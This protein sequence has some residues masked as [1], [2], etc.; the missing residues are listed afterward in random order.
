MFSTPALPGDLRRPPRPARGRSKLESGI[1]RIL[2]LSSLIACAPLGLP[3]AAR[4]QSADSSDA[5]GE[6][7][8]SGKA[9]AIASRA[10]EA[11]RNAYSDTSLHNFRARAE[12]HVFFLGE[13][14][15]E[16]EVVR[17]D[18]VALE[19]MWQAPGR[20]LQR[21]VGRRH[22]KRLPTGIRYHID[23]LSVVLDNFGNRIRLGEGQEVRD[24]LHPAAPG[25]LRYYQYRLVDSLEIRIRDQATRVYRLQVR[26]RDPKSPGVVGTLFVD[27]ASAAIAR[28]RLTFTASAYRDPDLDYINI[29]LKS[30]LW[31]GRHWLPVEQEVE[32][33]RQVAWLSF[34]VGGV[35][36]TRIHVFDYRIN[37]TPPPYRLAAGERVVSVSRE[38][39]ERF[40][41]WR[42]PFQVTPL[43]AEQSARADIAALRARVRKLVN[44]SDLIGRSPFQAFLPNASGVLRTRRAEGLLV[45]AGGFARVGPGDEA[46]V[47][48]GYP[49]GRRRPEIE[50]G[51]SRTLSPG[52]VRLELFLN[53][54]SDIGPEAAASGIV[55]TLG[56]TFRGED[57]TDPYFESGAGLRFTG[58]GWGGV[59]TLRLSVLRQR[60]G[61]LE[62]DDLA[63]RTPRPVRTIRNGTLVEFEAGIRRDFSDFLGASWTL[64]VRGQ[65]ATSALGDFGFTRLLTALEARNAPGDRRWTWNTRLSTAVAGGRLPPQRSLLLG[66]RGSVPGYR[67]R[68]WA[69]DRSAYLNF[70]VSRA[71]RQP[72]VRL[73]LLGAAGWTDLTDVGREAATVLAASETVGIRAAVGP[74]V[75]LFYD[76][77]RVDAL[78]GLDDGIWEV[79]FSIN[80]AFWSIL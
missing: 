26:P 51:Y 40:A 17:S 78:R 1:A 45:G 73:R 39:L 22:R 67:F 15:G 28:M 72:W 21:I 2:A 37:E 12:G 53:R 65:A 74:G 18:Q 52:T 32:I 41:D 33:R 3:D 63:R 68:S 59:E 46:S 10:T 61:S 43:P 20:S 54:L 76:I 58:H 7:W 27:R 8:D 47:W 19:L 5:A 55:S 60:A 62:V 30:G 80:P 23:H 44:P 35:I 56:L 34:P 42:E 29:D 77:L 36:R 14:Q 79:M 50:L 24:V 31:E 64:Q 11:R 66:G 9:I 57:Y 25:A 70:S 38:A 6:G 75:G 69:G 71:L 16:R 49:F 13:F 4:A 48:G